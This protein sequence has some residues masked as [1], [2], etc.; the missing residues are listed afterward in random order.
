MLQ[1]APET[2][3][4]RITNNLGQVE[5]SDFITPAI[6]EIRTLGFKTRKLTYAKFKESNL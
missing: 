6:V 2:K 1:Q 3:V 5:V 4:T